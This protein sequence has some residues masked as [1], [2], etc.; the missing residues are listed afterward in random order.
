[1]NFITNPIL[2]FN[3]NNRLQI[4][5]C[6]YEAPENLK[7]FT[8]WSINEQQIIRVTGN[9]TKTASNYEFPSFEITHTNQTGVYRCAIF[10]KARMRQIVQSTSVMVSGNYNI[11][12]LFIYIHISNNIESSVWMMY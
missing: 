6:K 8:Y 12:E 4:S 3:R 11:M 7:Q 5:N 1:M 10:D 9:T 2:S